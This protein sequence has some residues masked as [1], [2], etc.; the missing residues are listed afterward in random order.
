LPMPSSASLIHPSVGTG[1]EYRCIVTFIHH[2]HTTTSNT[3]SKET[4][5]KKGD[6]SIC[7][8]SSKIVPTTLFALSGTMS[9]RLQRQLEEINRCPRRPEVDDSFPTPYLQV[10]LHSITRRRRAN[11][12]LVQPGLYPFPGFV[13]LLTQRVNASFTLSSTS[14][15]SRY[16]KDSFS[17]SSTRIRRKAFS[18]STACRCF[19]SLTYRSCRRKHAH[20]QSG[21]AGKQ[22]SR[23]HRCGAS[24]RRTGLHAGRKSAN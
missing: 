12:W 11:R 4:S 5:S 19:T 13:T 14:T 18:S 16:D 24:C 15:L 22:G 9:T 21:R 1:M 3:S 20:E 6:K 17:K 10:Q 8:V 23:T 2:E 7:S